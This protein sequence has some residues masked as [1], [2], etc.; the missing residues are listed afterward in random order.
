MNFNRQSDIPI[1]PPFQ[2]IDNVIRHNLEKCSSF[3][4]MRDEGNDGVASKMA[5]VFRPT[6]AIQLSALYIFSR[7]VV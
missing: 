4:D 2:Y 1:R 3:V 6:S 5:A 7:L